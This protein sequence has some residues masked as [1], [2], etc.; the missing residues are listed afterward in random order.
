VLLEEFNPAAPRQQDELLTQMTN[1]I[2]GGSN[3]EEK[4]MSVK[5]WLL[6][7]TQSEKRKAVD[8]NQAKLGG[9]N[10]EEFNPFVEADSHAK[11]LLCKN[12]KQQFLLGHGT[13]YKND[14]DVNA[15]RSKEF[16]R[17]DAC[18]E[19]YLDHV[20]GSLPPLSFLERQF[21]S[22]ERGIVGNPH[23]AVE[24]SDELPRTGQKLGCEAMFPFARR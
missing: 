11:D 3:M 22:L 5:A 13:A 8:E 19:I 21:G 4:E 14:A 1:S 7:C 10:L 2:H 6:R 12:D 20:G 15:F 16:E 9:L 24:G 17:L 23:S 18:K